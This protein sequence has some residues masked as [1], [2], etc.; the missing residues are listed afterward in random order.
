M[1]RE[2]LALEKAEKEKLRKV[3]EGTQDWRGGRTIFE[4]AS[5]QGSEFSL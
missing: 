5:F 1:K 2:K 4:M 3:S